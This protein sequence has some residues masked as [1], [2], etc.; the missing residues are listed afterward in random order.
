MR[1]EG[2]TDPPYDDPRVQTALDLA[3]I[4]IDKLT[5]WWFEPRSS[6]MYVDGRGHK[7][8]YLGVPIVDVTKVEIGS[9]T[10]WREIELADLEV[11]NRHLS[12]QQH[13]VDDRYNPKIVREQL[14][15]GEDED[16]EYGYVTYWP[17]GTR[18]VRVTGKFGY[19][20]YDGG[21]TE[22]GV[23]PELIKWACR[24]IA[25]KELPGMGSELWDEEHMRSRVL[26][27]KTRDQ[28]ITLGKA[29]TLSGGA[30]GPGGVLTGDPAIDAVLSLFRRPIATRGA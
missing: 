8:L 27:E 24:R 30:L 14:V 26:T 7:T 28:S 25:I 9:G 6:L 2:V 29:T 22:D 23:T 13:P 1:A 10:D 11:Y 17:T 21:I 19:T 3:T 20:D 4:L 18:N 16:P 12:G 15:F 5:G